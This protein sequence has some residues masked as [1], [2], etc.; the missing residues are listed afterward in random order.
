[1]WYPDLLRQRLGFKGLIVTDAMEMTGLRRLYPAG[2]SASG[3][4]AVDAIKAGND[5]IVLPS[6]LESAYH[7]ILEAVRNR[8]IAEERIDA[9][10]RRILMAKASVG[11]D[12]A[13]LVNI[14]Q[15]GTTV[16]LP[17]DMQ[18]AQQVADSAVTLVREQGPELPLSRNFHRAG[19]EKGG[20]QASAAG[21]SGLVSVLFVDDAR[22]EMGR[23]LARALL[24]RAP[25]SK[26]FY[27]DERN[28]GTLAG[29]IVE[30]VGQANVVIA[31]AYVIPTAAKLITVQGRLT[32]SVGL[33]DSMGGLLDRIM[34][35][36]AQ[37]T[38]LV[39][40]GS[41]YL[42]LSF[43][44]VTTYLCTY[45]SASS[46]E[47]AAVKALFGE[48]PIQGKLPVSLKSLADRGDGIQ[49]VPRTAAVR[50]GPWHSSL[51]CPHTV[52]SM[53]RADG[54]FCIA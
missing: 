52:E 42:A 5:V 51:T 23:E 12:K 8:E 46:S 25:G 49:L 27:V 19:Q 1:M 2:P 13:R 28:A 50:D 33:P 31:A 47:L 36:A 11:L 21:N 20:P 43:P 6:D 16:A 24:A 44:Q 22:G 30:A 53:G 35:V 3:R 18:L 14:E 39:A 45:S 9:S 40:M 4:A 34:E 15:I 41:P 10:V 7:G 17:G 37:K 38:V 32:N 29:N 48:I 54:P 26:I